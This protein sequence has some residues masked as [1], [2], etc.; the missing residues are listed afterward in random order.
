MPS[1]PVVDVPVHVPHTEPPPK[2]KVALDSPGRVRVDSVP[3]SKSI[4][5][6]VKRPR[7][8]DATVPDDS[9][10]DFREKGENIFLELFAGQEVLTDSVRRA[11]LNVVR[12]DDLLGEPFEI[13]NPRHFDTIKKYLRCRRVRWLH[14]APPCKTFSLARRRD[15]F[16]TV[17]RLRSKDHPEG[18]VNSDMVALANNIVSRFA[19]LCRVQIKAGGW[20][21]WKTRNEVTYGTFDRVPAS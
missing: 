10:S 13:M 12:V 17:E 5:K 11:G 1:V 3:Q 14:G 9:G 21:S 4:A 7:G 18:V 16:G 6:G 2:E 20:F 19:R 8:A 15:R